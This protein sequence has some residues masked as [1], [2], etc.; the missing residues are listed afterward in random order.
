MLGGLL[1][2]LAGPILGAASSLFGGERRNDAAE[3]AAFNQMQFQER[4]SNTAYQR[5]MAD[6][7]AAGLN[8]MLAYS[9]GGASVPVGASWV[10]EN[11]G[12]AASQSFAAI[13]TAGASA[14]QAETAA[15]IGLE[16]IQKTKQEV[17]NLKSVDQ[18]VQAVT[19][20]LGEEYQN[21]IKQGYNLTEVGNQL[22]MTIDKMR[23]E[24]NLIND[25]QFLVKAQEALSKAQA[26]LTENQTALTGLD[27]QAAQSLG[28]MGREAA[29]L[30]P[31]LQILVDVLRVSSRGR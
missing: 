11:I 29:Q 22:R 23:S 5:A 28:N 4:M 20:N 8:P 3:G 2:G 19:R 14:Q 25:Q 31:I 6:M 7:K 15:N 27:V 16:T 24:I 21:L 17:V 10:P 30:T 12:S 13:Q 26:G 18:Q 1:K 9:Q